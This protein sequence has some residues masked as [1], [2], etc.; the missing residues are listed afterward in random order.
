MKLTTTL[1][2]LLPAASLT[3]AAPSNPA[4]LFARQS[5]GSSTLSYDPRYDI[6]GTSLNQV[7]CSTGDYGLITE[8]F[9]TFDSLPSFARIGGAPTIPGNGSPNCGTCYRIEY[10]PAGGATNSIVITAIDAAPGGFNVAT[11]AMNQLTG[12]RAEELGRVDVTWTQVSRTD[13]GLPARP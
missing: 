9:S 3:L 5:T 10:T 8:G 6:G 13:C 7:A 2:A 4:H 11:E 12:G 1:L